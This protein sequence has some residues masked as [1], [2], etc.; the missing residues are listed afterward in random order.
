MTYYCRYPSPLGMLLLTGDGRNLPGLFM[1][2]EPPPGAEAAEEAEVFLQTKSWLDAYFRGMPPQWLPPLAPEGTAFQKQIWRYLLEIPFGE[3]CTYGKLAQR[4]AGDMGKQ[5]MSAQ[6]VGGAVGRNP[7]G[8][9]IPC[10]RCVGAKGGLTGYAWG[11]ERKHW[12]LDHEHT[13]GAERK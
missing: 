2:A 13:K 8:I 7:I 12:L 10:H 3:V 11:L 9:I 1:D 6:A 5:R 4:A